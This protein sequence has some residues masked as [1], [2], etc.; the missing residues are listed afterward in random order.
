MADI[1][2]HFTVYRGQH[3]GD[4]KHVA[5]VLRQSNFRDGLQLVKQ[6]PFNGNIFVDPKE[7]K[8]T[9]EFLVP[10]M[11]LNNTE[12]TPIVLLFFT[13]NLIL[14]KNELLDFQE[15]IKNFYIKNSSTR[16]RNEKWATLEDEAFLKT[17]KPFINI[18]KNRI[19]QT[20][21]LENKNNSYSGKDLFV[22]S[23]FESPT[24]EETYSVIS[25]NT[26]ILNFHSEQSNV[27]SNGF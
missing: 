2:A 11:P 17:V 13:T 26:D 18:A 8:H 27:G 7:A 4:L 21:H 14:D 25:Y 16:A 24:D 23:F 20:I 9:V 3:N 19:S 5:T 15:T 1:T 6:N 12:L 10:H 22:T